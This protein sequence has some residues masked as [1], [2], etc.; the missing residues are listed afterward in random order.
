MTT[1]YHHSGLWIEKLSSGTYRVGLSEKG[2][3]DLGEVMFA[4]ISAQEGSM[5]KGDA[6]LNVEGA[7]AVTEL[8]LPFDMDVSAVHKEV[9][10]E[11]EM[12]N[13][14]A[15]DSNWLLEG[16]G[17]TSEEFDGLEDKPFSEA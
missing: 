8:T 13:A 12:L 15:K 11:P 2:Q 6:I 3:D 17:L 4:E 14:E 16:T 7:K 10:D 1:K 5:S 9:E